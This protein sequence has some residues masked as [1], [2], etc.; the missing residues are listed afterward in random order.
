MRSEFRSANRQ[1]VNVRESGWSFA[2][3]VEVLPCLLSVPEASLA[4]PVVEPST[5][6]E[7]E[8]P[9]PEHSGCLTAAV[10]EPK[11]VELAAADIGTAERLVAAGP[12]LVGKSADIAAGGLPLGVER[13][14]VEPVDAGAVA[15]TP[16]EVHT[17]AVAVADAALDTERPAGSG[18]RMEPAVVG[19]AEPVDAKA[20]VERP[21][22]A[23]ESPE[24]NSFRMNTSS[25]RRSAGTD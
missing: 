20:V 4:Q 7:A 18:N 3:Q 15:G 16:A 25:S 13:T 19:T 9:V 6:A 5:F 17:V 24:R 23:S 21:G 8:Q 22:S 10:P 14:L 1:A 2:E 11:V 12:G